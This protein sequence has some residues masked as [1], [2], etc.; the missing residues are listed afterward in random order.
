MKRLKSFPVKMFEFPSENVPSFQIEREKE[1]IPG[2]REISE[3]Q[4]QRRGSA[5]SNRSF[6]PL[7]G[8][9]FH[10]FNASFSIMFLGSFPLHFIEEQHRPGNFLA[11]SVRAS[12]R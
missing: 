9:M 12:S 4:D 10:I 3:R 5:L 8:V 6:T 1:Q 2:K 11:S 7:P